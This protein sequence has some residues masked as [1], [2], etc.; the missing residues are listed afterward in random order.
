MEVGILTDF[1]LT[2]EYLAKL[3]NDIDFDEN[4]LASTSD[5]GWGCYT[6]LYRDRHFCTVMQIDVVNVS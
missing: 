5:S 4:T 6:T 2:R 3:R 1:Y